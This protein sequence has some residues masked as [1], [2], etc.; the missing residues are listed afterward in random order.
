[1]R[2]S[3]FT[4]IAV[5]ACCMQV[6]AQNYVSTE[7]S[8][9]N[10]ILEEYT[11]RNCGYCPDGHRI[12]NQ[13][14][15]NHPDRFWAINIHAG[16][17]SPTSYPNMQCSDG[18]IIHNAAPNLTGYPT[19]DVNRF[20]GCINRGAWA[21]AVNT[22]LNQA[23]EANIAG[24]CII[25]PVTKTATIT[26]EVYY[27]ANSAASTNNLT[28]A[29]LQDSIMGSQSGMSSNPGQ[30]VN[31]TYCHMHILRDIITDTWGEV[32]S[33][34]TAG[35]LVT[36]TYTYQIP[37]TIGNPN[38]VAVVV[39]HLSFLAWVAEG[40][41]TII[42]A[43]ELEVII[44]GDNGP[45]YPVIN[46]V[47]QNTNEI[48][49]S[50]LKNGTFSV[51]NGG[52]EDLTSLKF[53]VEV[54]GN[55]DVQEW[56]GSVASWMSTNVGFQAEISEGTHTATI[57]IIEANGE[58]IEPSE[59]TIASADFVGSSWIESQG[60]TNSV[61]IKIWQDRYGN[62]TTWELVS[63]DL[64]VLASDGPYDILP[65]N[66]TLYHEYIVEIEQ[67]ECVMFTIYDTG[68][69][70]I[71]NGNGEGH[72]QIEDENG[73]ILYSGDGTFTDQ[74]FAIMTVDVEMLG[75]S[76]NAV[77]TINVYPNPAKNILRISSEVS[78][79]SIYNIQG[80]LMMNGPVNGNSIDISSL[81]NGMYF[82]R[83]NVEGQVVD[84]K[85]VKE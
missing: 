51:V 48:S 85:F 37:E 17:F 60:L 18:I 45:I 68:G 30:I 25:N 3:I 20:T 42:T 76:D 64:T 23:S 75:M 36:K 9:R 5:V 24:V 10:A 22:Q 26:V 44:G 78:T 50:T 57:T 35:T 56:E 15:D 65:P 80:Q 8:N 74:D 6:N 71:N 72:Y 40:N 83:L 62:Q 79:A 63:H 59:Q 66:G 84:R 28:V 47:A 1:M 12:A 58:T 29:M 27:T 21:N 53:E 41:R 69:N 55:V 73:N 67:D 39:E 61:K 34:T 70:G 82:V 81:P 4:F 38:G 19:G 32:I 77:E 16:S 33:P 43:N 14:Q 52:S 46:Q 13:I 54:N 31:G 49:C 7:P 2:K 11:G